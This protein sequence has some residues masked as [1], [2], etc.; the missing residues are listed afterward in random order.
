[1]ISAIHNAAQVYEE[2]QQKSRRIETMIKV[3]AVAVL[4]FSIIKL[5]VAI[6]AVGMGPLVWPC[7]G[8]F[9]AYNMLKES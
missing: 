5:L 2:V 7:V 9:L 1:M 3:I 8:V 4:L 6:Y